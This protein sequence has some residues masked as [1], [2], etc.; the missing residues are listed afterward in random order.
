MVNVLAQ[1]LDYED[2]KVSSTDQTPDPAPSAIWPIE[3]AGL[4]A[5]VDLGLSEREIAR[6]FRVDEVEIFRSLLGPRHR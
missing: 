4:L 1:R 3:P 5:L 6:Y 2:V